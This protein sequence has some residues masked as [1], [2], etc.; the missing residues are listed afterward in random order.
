MRHQTASNPYAAE[1][2]KQQAVDDAKTQLNT[3]TT[4][5]KP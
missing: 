1:M 3:N 2:R 5:Q 4:S